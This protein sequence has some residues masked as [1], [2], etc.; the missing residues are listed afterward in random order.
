MRLAVNCPPVMK[1]VFTVTS[2]PLRWG[3]EASAMYTGTVIEAIP[4]QR[5]RDRQRRWLAG[6]SALQ[7]DW[8]LCSRCCLFLK[9]MWAY[10]KRCW[11]DFCNEKCAAY[12][13]MRACL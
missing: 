8:H 12:E 13:L 10:M 1:R 7:D 9:K 5:G 6:G 3:G 2:C 4:A 11:P